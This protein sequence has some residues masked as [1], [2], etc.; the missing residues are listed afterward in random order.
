MTLATLTV[1]A[2]ALGLPAGLR[3]LTRNAERLER[4]LGI[5]PSLTVFLKPGVSSQEATQIA[6]RI[7]QTYLLPISRIINRRQALQEFKK[8]A[9]V[10]GMLHFLGRHPLPAVLV[11][12]LPPA[13]QATLS[14]WS[15]QLSHWT[16]ISAI[17][18]D[19]AWLRR[20]AAFIS[21]LGRLNEVL[22]LLFALATCL[23]VG[24]TIR[25]DIE[26]ARMEIM[27]L[28]L[29]GAPG[30]FIRR[31]FLYRG[32]WYGLLGGICGFLILIGIF[33]FLA[34]PLSQLGRLYDATFVI[35]WPSFRLFLTLLLGGTLLGWV[36][37][38]FAIGHELQRDDSRF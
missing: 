33:S 31:P 21:F 4:P 15:R 34:A 20:L 29:L 36:G 2:I 22:Y 27:T 11:F 7:H 18:T 3:V 24:N 13:R 9:G 26:N 38:A 25:L 30:S 17:R 8:W 37:A 32:G 1:I 12:S 28:R 19:V 23:I 14:V 35:Q 6:R 16:G 5:T 10:H